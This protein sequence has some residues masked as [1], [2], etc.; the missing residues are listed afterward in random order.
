MGNLRDQTDRALRALL[1]PA[2]ATLG[3]PTVPIYISNDPN[4]RKVTDT[5]TN[6][7]GL[8]DIK[9]VQ[10]PETP[11]GSGC[12]LFTCLVRAKYP[13]ANQDG[14]AENDHR[15]RLNTIIGKVAD[16]LHQSNNG[17][18]Y[19]YTAQLIT[20]AGNDLATSAPTTDADLANF[21][22]LNL[23]HDIAGGDKSGKPHH[24]FKHRH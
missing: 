20:T 13:A 7:T 10:G 9:T 3:A 19:H 24:L 12:Y 6:P 4:E 21:S 11:A 17:Q 5:D 16:T 1:T 8:I 23:I 2:I 22:C 18:D 15:T 14:E